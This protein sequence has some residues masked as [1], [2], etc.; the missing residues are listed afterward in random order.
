MELTT[1][2]RLVRSLFLND[3][4]EVVTNELSLPSDDPALATLLKKKKFKQSFIDG[5]IQVNNCKF[6]W[7]D[8]TDTNICGLA[9]IMDIESI[10]NCT[11]EEDVDEDEEG[12]APLD[13]FH[14]V[15]MVRPD[16]AVGIFSG[17]YASDSLYMYR[18]NGGMELT[19][20]GPHFNRVAHAC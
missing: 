1:L 7:A 19:N 10:V 20:Q 4:V 9:E 11:C 14:L 15:D 13:K 8:P 12:V 5:I 6:K 16:R 2:F 18:M 17:K 3:K